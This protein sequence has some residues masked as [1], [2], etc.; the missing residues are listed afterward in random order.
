MVITTAIFSIIIFHD[1]KSF[2]KENQY[3]PVRGVITTLIRST[4]RSLFLTINMIHSVAQFFPTYDGDLYPFIIFH[5]ENFTLAMRHK[6]LSCVLQNDNRLRISF[7]LVNFSTP[8]RQSDES[9]LEKPM[10]YRL[11]C[12]F[13]TYDI[14]YH[15]IIVRG[16]YD[17]LMRM[18]DD[19]YFSDF[20]KIDPFM[21][22]ASRKLDYIYRSTYNEPITPMEPILQRFI[23]KKVL[24]LNCIYNNFFVMRLK[25]FYKSKRIQYFLRELIDDD[26]I[27]REYIGDGC[28]H[29]A[30]LE[31]DQNTKSEQISDIPYGHNYH[32]MPEGKWGMKFLYVHGF[33][34]EF[35]KSCE[36]LMVLRRS[37]G[38]IKQIQIS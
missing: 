11:M 29:A 5:D 38:V 33:L 22:T 34:Q 14:Y 10:G 13:W 2:I 26:L 6:L 1:R 24:R 32:L 9:R 25:W 28:A 20:M 7:A 17:Y 18:D 36:Q 12:R 19:S 30:M 8:V 27:L 16:N 35:N 23:G 21:Y 3:P 31:V 4:D 15:P 37:Q